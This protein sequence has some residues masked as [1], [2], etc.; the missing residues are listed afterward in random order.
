MVNTTNLYTNKISVLG[1]IQVAAD[2]DLTSLPLG[3][4][5]KGNNGQTVKVTRSVEN[6]GRAPLVIV[7]NGDEQGKW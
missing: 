1:P 4:Q 7:V 3:I 6:I 5:V 2:A